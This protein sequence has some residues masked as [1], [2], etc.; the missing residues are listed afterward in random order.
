MEL[1]IVWFGL[2]LIVGAYANSKGHSFVGMF[3]LAVVISPLLAGLIELIRAANVVKVEAKAVSSGDQ[4]KCP[5]CAELVK[6]EAV[7][8]RFCGEEL[9]PLEKP[10][11]AKT[12]VDTMGW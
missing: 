9:P 10:V 5:S 6:S 1:F 7:K 2:A 4:R 3:L 11:G 12:P 8:C